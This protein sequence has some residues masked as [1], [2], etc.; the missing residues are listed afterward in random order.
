[1]R[2]AAI[3]AAL[4]LL[5][6]CGTEAAS[7]IARDAGGRARPD[8][9]DAAPG[10]DAGP[11]ADGGALA[12]AEARP[13]AEPAADAGAAR[14][15]GSRTGPP[16]VETVAR[17]LE[18]PWAIEFLPD[19]RALV[20]ERPGRLRVLSRGGRLSGAVA[21]TPE[22]FA[23]GQGGL[24]DVARGPSFA[25]DGLVYVCYA[26]RGRGG[27]NTE[28]ARGRL[29]GEALEGVE[30]IFRAEP[31]TSRGSNH[32]GC[33]IGFDPSGDLFLGL[34][35]RF[36]EL[37][38]AQTLDNHL[39]KVIRL[40][41][42]GSIP[43]DNPFVGQSGALDA[44]WSYGHRN[45]QG[46]AIHPRTGAVWTVEH[47]PDGGDEVNVPRA[48]E[49]YGWPLASYGSHYDGRDIPDE[50]QERG[51][52][53]PVRWWTP[54]IAPSGLMFYAG[55]LFP[56]WRGHLFVGALAGQ[57]LVRLE[58][59]GAQVQEETRLLEGE[60][61]IRDMT[62]GPEGAIYVVTDARDGRVLRITRR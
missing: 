29:A 23:S 2:S 28:V 7:D 1:M 52:V 43:P 55:D 44:I 14:D 45:I 59:E 40:R 5:A 3:A 11:A 53:E 48:G 9:A 61:R 50:H 18:H 34:G 26:A 35:D 62:T 33:R 30:V 32:F 37:E 27:A 38:R 56:E 8:A 47:G 54:S 25:Q 41:P 46:L 12:D 16:V 17:G 24:L 19:G 49:N 15:A 4:A 60:G 42:D 58:L 13:D 20:T 21:G 57:H 10:E 39:G 6:G 51:F 31:K 36:T 22:V